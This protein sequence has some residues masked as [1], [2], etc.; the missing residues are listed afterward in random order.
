MWSIE[1][2]P[3]FEEWFFSLDDADREN[4]LASVLLLQERGS[5]LS[6][7]HADTVKGS[8]FANMKELRIQRLGRTLELFLRLTR[9][10]QAS[11]YALATRVGMTNGFTMR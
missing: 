8:Q 5:M 6:R 3:I 9:L 2:T 7:P 11:F 4:V 10:E 1:Q